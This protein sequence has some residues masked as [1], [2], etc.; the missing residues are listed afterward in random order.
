MNG[1]NPGAT[2]DFVVRTKLSPPRLGGGLV[3]RPRLL[4]PL[5]R[6]LRRKLTLIAAPAGYGKT[7][8]A[9]AWL[10]EQP[11][12]TAWLSLDETDMEIWDA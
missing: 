11:Y 7:T 10:Q 5:N 2:N 3:A 6:G 8:Q 9:V 4:E 12:P 1:Q